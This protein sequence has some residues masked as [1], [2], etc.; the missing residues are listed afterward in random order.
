M[1]FE[2]VETAAFENYDDAAQMYDADAS[3]FNGP[4]AGQGTNRQAQPAKKRLRSSFDLTIFNGA[5]TP[6]LVELFNELNSFL[7]KQRLEFVNGAY[8][9][10]PV[11]SSPSNLIAVGAGTVGFKEN[12]D[13]YVRGAANDATQLT[14]SCAQ[15][16]YNGLFEASGKG[17]G[18]KIVSIR[19]TVTS[20]GQIDNEIVHTKST[21]LGARSQ[22]RISP[23]TFF[24]PEQ[25]QNK[26]IDIPVG[27]V[28]NAE[29]GIDYLVNAGET[30]KWNVIIE[31]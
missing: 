14:V 30:V 24:R 13:L 5:A 8:L 2:N 6:L 3:N 29:H 7:K 25:F 18:F 1:P 22:N 9:Y 23:R 31:R 19:M 10:L 17:I 27:M 20:D 11:T 28:I 16:P 12:G 21:F 26:I 15:F 4:V